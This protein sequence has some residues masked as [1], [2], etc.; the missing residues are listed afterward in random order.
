MPADPMGNSVGPGPFVAMV[1]TE[2]GIHVAVLQQ[3]SPVY[4][5]HGTDKKART[6]AQRIGRA[7]KKEHGV[8]PAR[9][10]AKFRDNREDWK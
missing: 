6:E 3:T 7:L 5:V 2:D 1:E 4:Y 8:R 10:N 9:F